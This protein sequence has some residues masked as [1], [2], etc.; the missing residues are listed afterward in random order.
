MQNPSISSL[1]TLQKQLKT[2]NF[3]AKPELIES[4]Y[5]ALASQWDRVY[6]E[7]SSPQALGE[8]L[9]IAALMGYAPVGEVQIQIRSA[10]QTDASHFYKHLFL[11]AVQKKTL[12]E[13]TATP[14]VSAPATPQN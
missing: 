12:T 3:Q 8:K 14:A 5:T 10:I 13:E 2:Q 11:Q 1:E 7:A 4:T 9:H 6:L